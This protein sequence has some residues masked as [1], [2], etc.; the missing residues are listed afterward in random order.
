MGNGEPGSSRPGLGLSP[1]HPGVDGSARARQGSA[2][3]TPCASLLCSSCRTQSPSQ[4]QRQASSLPALH[5]SGPGSHHPLHPT[6]RCSRIFVFSAWPGWLSPPGCHQPGGVG[7]WRTARRGWAAP[8]VVTS[9]PCRHEGSQ[10]VPD[11]GEAAVQVSAP[12][13]RFLPPKLDGGSVWERTA[14]PR[15]AKPTGKRLGRGVLPPWGH[16]RGSGDILEPHL[17]EN[18]QPHGVG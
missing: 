13:L 2:G 3:G 15:S 7:D 10:Q 16:R 11:A 8:L 6:P 17:V 18:P 4:L 9:G 14:G 12:F 5:R 1:N